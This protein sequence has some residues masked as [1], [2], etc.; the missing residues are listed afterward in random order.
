MRVMITEAAEFEILA[1]DG[2]SI[3]RLRIRRKREGEPDAEVLA[4]T[5]Q[6]PDA[7]KLAAE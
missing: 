1:A 2:R 5:D 7:E 3:K 6:R 4:I